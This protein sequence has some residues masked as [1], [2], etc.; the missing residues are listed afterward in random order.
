MTSKSRY[1]VL[2][3]MWAM[4][5]LAAYAVADPQKQTTAAPPQGANT[6]G[7]IAKFTSTKAVG[8]SNITEDNEG[9]IG[10]GTKLP[11][12]TLTVNGVI[13][14]LSGGI[15]F[16]NGTIQTTAGLATVSRDGSLK[17][18]GTQTNPLAV[19]APLILT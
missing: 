7:R 17:G 2:A 5:L 11:T 15:K 9:N 10:I 6:P 14:M 18:D 13:E 8:D 1:T 4:I 12:S 19:G 3:M 16:P